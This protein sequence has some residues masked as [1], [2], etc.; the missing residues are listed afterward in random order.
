VSSKARQRSDHLLRDWCA[1]LSGDVLSIGSKADRDGT[2]H[3]YRDYFRSARS[4][5]TSEV[6]PRP[7]CDR[8]LDV[9]AMPD[10]EDASFDV[11]F[12][13]GVLE[14][15]DDCHAAVAECYRILR[16]GGVFLVGLPFQQRLH[17]VPHDFW[18]F[19]RY[20][21]EVLL[22]AF[23]VEAIEPIGDDPKFPWTYWARARKAATC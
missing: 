6:A 1:S 3:T 8:V 15:V 17:C 13:S 16:P 7:E 23:A 18:R 14:H 4:Y 19:T 22:R 10:V 20:G 5:T 11:V 2:G 21:V 9:R 12:C